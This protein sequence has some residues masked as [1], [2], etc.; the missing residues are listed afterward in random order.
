MK[1]SIEK[2]NDIKENIR[3][4]QPCSNSPHLPRPS[5]EEFVVYPTAPI[6]A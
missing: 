5:S 3:A 2:K 1:Y 6:T 4:S